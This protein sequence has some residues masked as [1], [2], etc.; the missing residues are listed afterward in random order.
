MPTLNYG[1]RDGDGG[2]PPRVRV[3]LT[4]P[5][6]RPSVLVPGKTVSTNTVTQESATGAGSFADFE[7][8]PYDVLVTFG[9]PGTKYFS[10][11][12]MIQATIE[13]PNADADLGPLIEAATV[14]P[15]VGSTWVSVVSGMIAGL[16]NTYAPL[17]QANTT[18]SAG[19]PVVLPNG[20]IGKRTTSGT[21]RP[22]FDATEIAAW[23]VTSGG[24]GSG[25]LTVTDNGDGTLTLTSGG[26]ST[27][28]DAGD[29]T[30][31]FS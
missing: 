31:V 10:G 21:S 22:S 11:V 26:S 8:G 29:G 18:Y 9:R 27:V 15:P 30:L 12:G 4:P 7:P 19:A 16:A 24:G 20:T 17:W 14:T 2:D 6:V 1:W 28:T 25:G 5:A 13:M 3:R 23:T